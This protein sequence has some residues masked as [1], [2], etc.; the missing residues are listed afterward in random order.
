MPVRVRLWARLI[1]GLGKALLRVLLVGGLVWIAILIGIQVIL[2]TE[3]GQ[4]LIRRQ[5]VHLLSDALETEVEIQK[6]RLSGIAEITLEGFVLYDKACQP[7]IRAD[8][9]R[10]SWY[11]SAFWRGLWAGRW[12]IPFSSLRLIKPLVFI[13]T[14]KASKMTNVD[15]LFATS[16]T[17]PSKAT[18]W[19]ASLPFIE[20]QNGKLVW[21]DSTLPTPE[22]LPKA[23]FLRYGHLRMD[24]L[25]LKAGVEW[26]GEGYLFAQVNNLSLVEANS[27]IRIAQLNLTLQAYPDSTRISDLFI[28]LPKSKITGAGYFPHEGL[29]KLFKDT[30]TKLFYA[31]IAGQIDW[32]EIAAFAGNSLP[33]RGTWQAN[34]KL[35]GDLY[36]FHA[37]SFELHLSPNAFIKGSGEIIHY[38]KP[39]LTYWNLPTIE[40][41]FSLADLAACIP[42]IGPLPSYLETSQIWKIWGRHTG[43]FGF[44]TA[45]IHTTGAHLQG[46]LQKDSTWSYSLDAEFSDWQLSSAVRQSSIDT[47]SGKIHL[48]GTDFNIQRLKGELEAQMTLSD[49]SGKEWNVAARATLQEGMANGSFTLGSLYGTLRYVGQ[50][51]LIPTGSYVGEG[52]LTGISAR[53]WGGEGTVEGRFEVTGKEIPWEKGYAKVSMEELYWRWADTTYNLGPAVLSIQSGSIY[54][55]QAAGLT[56]RWRGEGAW[57]QALPQWINHWTAN[58]TLYQDSLPASWAVQGQLSLRDPIWTDI[59]GLP[60]DLSIHDLSVH[61][62]LQAENKAPKGSINWNADSIKYNKLTLYSPYLKVSLNGD[63]I[64]GELSSVRG[65]IYVKYEA[66][67]SSLH[68]TWRRGTLSLHTLFQERSDTAALALLWEYF[69]P[70]LRVYVDTTSSILI[71]GGRAW[72]FFQAEPLSIDV[73]RGDWKAEKLKLEGQGAQ[74]TLS[75]TEG[76]LFISVLNFPIDAGTH[77]FGLDIPL[78]GQ[79]SL[80]WQDQENGPRFSIEID[81]LQYENQK[82]PYIQ[83]LGEPADDSVAFQIAVQEGNT[84]FL[85]G[86]GIYSLKDTLSPLYA[87]LRSVR[88]PVLWLTPFLGEYIRNAKGTFIAQRLILRGKPENPNIYGEV[89]CNNI[90]FFVPLTRVSYVVDGALRLRG[91]TVFF[92]N[93]E[94]REAQGKRSYINGLIALRGWTAPYLQLNL[95][96]KDKPF[97]LAASSATTDAYLYGRAELENGN[98]SITGPWTKPTLQGEVIFSSSTDLTLPLHTYE[99]DI[100]AEHVR[101]ISS[102]DTTTKA[103][104]FLAPTGVDIRVVIRSVP[105]ARFRLLFDER[106]GDE[107]VAQGIANLLFSINRMGQMSL[108]GAYEIQSGEYRINLQGVASK[109][110]LLEP[111]SRISW[112]GDL[113]QGQMNITATYRTFSSLRMIDTTF[114]HNVPVELKVSLQGNLLS[115]IMRFF[116]DIPSLSGTATPLVNLFLQRLSSDEQERNRQVFAL[117][118]LGSFIPMEQGFGSQ[119]V[120]S[121]VSST[122]AEFIS[123]QLASWVGQMLGSQVGVAFALG[124]WNEL[125]AQLRISLGQRLTIER[126]GVLISPGQNTAN[127]G[128]LSARYRLMP[129]RVT[130]PTQ[131][132]L[133]AEGFSRQS[134]M[135]GAAGATSQGAGLRLRKS[136]YL[137]ERR[138]RRSYKGKPRN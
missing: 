64:E 114:T 5:L 119:Q 17:T 133:E 62:A 9:L 31:E 104:S 25:F 130:Q 112:D 123:A 29:D 66:L 47:I 61:I 124:E 113:Y 50:L 132:Q 26:T 37:E 6:L 94:L 69:P 116:I 77:L 109:R 120:R 80:L 15:R 32:D 81:S 83:V 44:Y 35:H 21:I 39:K 18:P 137:P 103:D 63:S 74:I 107:I 13:Y 138:E 126:D 56:L 73:E 90:S 8:E 2:S 84:P 78:R 75:H 45:D 12:R 98:I 7:F 85:T 79:A 128:N 88:V 110:L 3:R 106:T 121:G 60:L 68:G 101:F 125:S 36:R 4:S 129:K 86:R 41:E 89:F 49:T 51:P 111:G 34:I 58:D 72:H 57:F 11:P 127:I 16:D 54:E 92:P 19:K 65:D 1:R 97:L 42:D 102:R 28:Q 115:P 27:H 67:H 91:D 20:I 38:A 59:A 22:I 82:Y 24:S 14:E 43:R 118:V 87:D 46:T 105:E 134:F 96:L 55:F 135:W 136:F 131:W 117:L 108:S 100:G 23:G 40:A 122:L 48:S 71:L 10:V 99:R 33:L 53:L 95:R 30:E 93:V 70:R 52:T 76:K